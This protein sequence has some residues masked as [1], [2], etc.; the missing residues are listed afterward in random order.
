MM[1][2][3]KTNGLQVNLEIDV[4]PP[5]YPLLKCSYSLFFVEEG[6]VTVGFQKPEKEETDSTRLIF[7]HDNETGFR[8]KSDDWQY[9]A[10]T[11]AEF[12]SCIL[13]T[14][15]LM[16]PDW[17][18]IS[19]LLGKFDDVILGIDTNIISD[20]VITKQLIEGFAL[21]STISHKRTP[22]WVLV[23]IPQ[24]VMHE[25]ENQANERIEPRGT[26]S[27]TGRLALRALAEIFQ[28]HTLDIVGIS[29]IVSGDAEP[30]L[31]MHRQFKRLRRDINQVRTDFMNLQE[32]RAKE[33]GIPVERRVSKLRTGEALV[34]SQIRQ[35][36]RDTQ[37]NKGLHFLTEDRINYE[38]ART[39]SLPSVLY[40][41]PSGE[42]CNDSLQKEGLA[43]TQLPFNIGG[44]DRKI[45][46]RV[47]LSRVLYE[48]ATAYG[49]VTVSWGQGNLVIR[50][51]EKG[52]LDDWVDHVFYAKSEELEKLAG[53][54]SGLSIDTMVKLWS[55]G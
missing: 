40:S 21:N 43:P 41:V 17:R 36:M 13:R 16:S 23:V 29:V 6:S 53:K 10:K 18:D 19:D 14:G 54:Y 12:T 28:M 3:K 30:S 49:D 48:L 34:R 25:L 33:T 11:P 7:S 32:D 5:H 52:K 15:M 2:G 45:S 55:K 38:L 50:T 24:V 37:F 47:A 39:E 22:N 9:N 4:Q 35:F 8:I 20:C 46:L 44:H 26:L 51:D 31:D 1:V 42:Q 27:A